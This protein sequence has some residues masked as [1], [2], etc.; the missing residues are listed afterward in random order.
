[1]EDAWPT[2]PRYVR[3]TTLNWLFF[4]ACIALLS[5]AAGELPYA[6]R[7]LILLVLVVSVATQFAAA[8]RLIAGQDEF[9]RAVTA[10]RGVAAGGLTLTVAVAYGLV[11]QFMGAPVVPMWVA[12]PLFWGMFGLATPFIRSSRP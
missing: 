7:W 11:Q 5:A 9:V 4:L 2:S 1:M 10:K 3:W 12:Y 8:Y 6:L